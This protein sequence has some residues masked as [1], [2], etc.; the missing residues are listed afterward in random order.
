MFARYLLKF[1]YRQVNELNRDAVQACGHDVVRRTR[2]KE[3]GRRRG[4]KKE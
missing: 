2:G 4:A 1:S 3:R